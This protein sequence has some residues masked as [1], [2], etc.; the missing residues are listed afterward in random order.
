MY[1][2]Y[3]YGTKY[4]NCK[5]L[6]LVYPK[7][8]EVLKSSYEYFNDT[9][10]KLPLEICFFDVLESKEKRDNLSNCNIFKEN[11]QKIL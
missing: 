6:Y 2:L 10:K 11:S 5:K 8:G 9:Q 4:E 7:D 3:A 1:Q